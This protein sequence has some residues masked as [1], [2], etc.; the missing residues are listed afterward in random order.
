MHGRR[1]ILQLRIGQRT[2]DDGR[3]TTP[4]LQPRPANGPLECPP[5][6]RN[7]RFW[8]IP[9][10]QPPEFKQILASVFRVFS[11]VFVLTRQEFSIFPASFGKIRQ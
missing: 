9:Q 1:T 2:T 8:E 10:T 5:C 11:G 6:R 4:S 7:N 3:P